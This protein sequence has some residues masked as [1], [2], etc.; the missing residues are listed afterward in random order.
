VLVVLQLESPVLRVVEVL[1]AKQVGDRGE[2][3]GHM[4][5]R[6]YCCQWGAVVI[7]YMNKLELV[8]RC[9]DS[10]TVRI[11]VVAGEIAE[12]NVQQAVGACEQQ[13]RYLYMMAELVE[14]WQ[15]LAGL[16]RGSLEA[17]WPPSRNGMKPADA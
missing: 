11:A 7:V 16:Y 15:K 12:L 4:G 6:T 2:V 17:L 1:H 8:R 9:I 5:M 10:N 3:L 13:H 14:A